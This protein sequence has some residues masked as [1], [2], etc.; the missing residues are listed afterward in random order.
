MTLNVA[1]LF[2]DAGVKATASCVVLPDGVPAARIV[3]DI[4]EFGFPLVLFPFCDINEDARSGKLILALIEELSLMELGT[5]VLVKADF[6]SPALLKT[7]W[8]KYFSDMPFSGLRTDLDE[9][10]LVRELVPNLLLGIYPFPGEFINRVRIDADGALTTCH[11]MQVPLS[12][13]LAVTGDLRFHPDK[14]L[15]AQ[16]VRSYHM[17]YWEKYSS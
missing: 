1:R 16:E 2:A 17:D 4:S 10:F 5:K 8:E 7:V 3:R 11:H 12:E 6:L 9:G 15:E 13:R 14:W